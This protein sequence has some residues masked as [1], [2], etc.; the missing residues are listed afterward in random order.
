[1]TKSNINTPLVRAG[2]WVRISSPRPLGRKQGYV[3]AVHE[4]QTIS[5]GYLDNK[6]TAVKENL[7]W[8]GEYWEFINPDPDTSY[9]QESDRAIV[10]S[11]PPHRYA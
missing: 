11:G 4:D 2:D 1:M 10:E 8:N 5:V 6:G 7:F 9:L 3:F